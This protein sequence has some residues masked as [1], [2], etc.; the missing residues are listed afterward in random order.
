MT[1]LYFSQR[2]G[3]ADRGPGCGGHRETSEDLLS[4]CVYASARY[5][6]KSL[7]MRSSCGTEHV[8]LLFGD[9]P[10]CTAGDGGRSSRPPLRAF[11]IWSAIKQTLKMVKRKQ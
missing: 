4:V 11:E 9:T 3:V 8:S 10:R 5:S 7:K 1:F 2:L 6:G